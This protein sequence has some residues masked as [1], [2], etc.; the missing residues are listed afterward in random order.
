MLQYSYILSTTSNYVTLSWPIYAL[1]L[2]LQSESKMG[3]LSTL[4]K[5]VPETP[6]IV[7]ESTNVKQSD[8][9]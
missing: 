4:L 7:L 2:K 3:Y 5:K 1:Q 9:E 6:W 8:S